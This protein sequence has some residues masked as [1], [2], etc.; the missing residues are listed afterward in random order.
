MSGVLNTKGKIP[1]V[2]KEKVQGVSP[3]WCQLRARLIGPCIVVTDECFHYRKEGHQYRVCRTRLGNKSLGEEQHKVQGRVHVMTK[4]KQRSKQQWLKVLFI[5]FFFDKF[6]GTILV[7][8]NYAYTSFDYGSI[9]SFITPSYA[10]RS[11][12]KT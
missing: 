10:I 6:E 5:F 2:S 9:H 11:W 12:L 3:D 4:S 1:M 7:I 8:G